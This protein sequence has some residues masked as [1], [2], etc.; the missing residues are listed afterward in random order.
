MDRRYCGGLLSP[1]LL[2]RCLE[3]EMEH[4][5]DSIMYHEVYEAM[6]E[7]PYPL[8]STTGRGCNHTLGSQILR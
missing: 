1:T 7:V 5:G 3:G 8:T 6:G 2:Q 4:E